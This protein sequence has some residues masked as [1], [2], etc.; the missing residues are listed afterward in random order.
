LSTRT[1]PLAASNECSN[2]STPASPKVATPTKQTHNMKEPFLSYTTKPRLDWRRTTPKNNNSK[3]LSL[4]MH[5]PKERD[6]GTWS[7][8]RR[9]RLGLANNGMHCAPEEQPW[10]A[11]ST[12]GG[13][14]RT[15][16]PFLQT[17]SPNRVMSPMVKVHNKWDISNWGNRTYAHRPPCSWSYSAMSCSNRY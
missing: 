7:V 9:Y 14:P 13:Q 1:L 11:M 3:E 16:M 8:S 12:G 17:Q 5:H 4:S 10:T 15:S 6:G 2:D